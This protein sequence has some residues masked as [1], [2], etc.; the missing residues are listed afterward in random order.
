MNRSC[1]RQD[2]SAATGKGKGDRVARRL[3]HDQVESRIGI[4]YAVLRHDVVGGTICNHR[5]V[6]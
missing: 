3:G 5:L 4:V 6:S 1:Q 2:T